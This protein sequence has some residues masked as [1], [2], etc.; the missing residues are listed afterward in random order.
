MSR[1]LWP[2][3]R[4]AGTAVLSSLPV[5]T[6]SCSQDHL[7]FRLGVIWDFLARDAASRPRFGPH[8]LWHPAHRAQG[9]TRH[10]SATGGRREGSDGWTFSAWSSVGSLRAASL[11]RSNT[12]GT[13]QSGKPFMSVLAAAF[14]STFSQGTA[15]G[16]A[17]TSG[18]WTFHQLNNNTAFNKQY[19]ARCT[20]SDD[21]NSCSLSFALLP[22]FRIIIDERIFQ[23]FLRHLHHLR[24]RLANLDLMSSAGPSVSS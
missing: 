24:H 16:S 12:S 15:T 19:D 21:K 8:T 23:D 3:G 17:S 9:E 6:T 10:Q 14:T 7:C 22:I 1:I 5:V 2:I 11:E 20:L 4:S 18:A 13:S